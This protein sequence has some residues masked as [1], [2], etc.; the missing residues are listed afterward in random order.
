MNTSKFINNLVLGV[1]FAT[2]IRNF[3]TN[4]KRVT[5]RYN[6]YNKNTQKQVKENNNICIQMPVFKSYISQNYNWHNNCRETQN[7]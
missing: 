5:A 6:N 4:T 2:K 1:T 3:Y 7:E